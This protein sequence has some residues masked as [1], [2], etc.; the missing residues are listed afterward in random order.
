MQ[1]PS[2][3]Q[4]RMSQSKA[5]W[6]NDKAYSVS[7]EDE[8]AKLKPGDQITVRVYEGE[9]TFCSEWPSLTPRGPVMKYANSHSHMIR[10]AALI[11]QLRTN[12]CLT[13]TPSPWRGDQSHRAPGTAS[14]R[15]DSGSVRNCDAAGP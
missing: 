3:S 10:M 5:G 9:R 15:G 12:N 11:A 1:P 8:P 14:A 4:S 2:G 13:F 6:A 7:N